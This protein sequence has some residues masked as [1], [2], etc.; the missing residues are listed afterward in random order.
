MKRRYE[1]GSHQ[2]A[3]FDWAAYVK[4]PEGGMLKDYI[5][6]IPNGGKIGVIKGAILKRQGVLAGVPDIC[7]S[8]PRKAYHGMFLELK[9]EAYFRIT[10][11]Q[12]VVIDRLNK[13][14]YCARVSN[15]IDKTIE[16]IEEYLG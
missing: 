14:G 16:M 13:V 12:H 6:A 9:R 4:V 10:K 11:E 3:L 15:T 5:F 1:E 8:L 2:A 7:L